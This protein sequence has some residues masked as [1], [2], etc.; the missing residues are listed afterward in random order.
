MSTP[1]VTCLATTSATA[2]SDWA[3]KATASTGR[4]SSLA[5]IRSSSDLGR[6]KLPTW[7]V[8]M[9]SVL[10]FI[11]VSP[12]PHAEPAAGPLFMLH[13]LRDHADQRGLADTPLGRDTAHG[14]AVGAL[15]AGRNILGL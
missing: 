7:V 10:N 12:H 4:P 14:R 9:R 8:R 11:A 2:A 5:K 1:A 6:G 13:D 3:S 15:H